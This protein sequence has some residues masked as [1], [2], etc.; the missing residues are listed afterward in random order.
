MIPVS[1][2]VCSSYSLELV[3]V[4]FL[5]FFEGAFTFIKRCHVIQDATLQEWGLSPQAALQTQ[6]KHTTAEKSQQT[7]PVQ[8]QTSLEKTLEKALRVLGSCNTWRC[9]GGWWS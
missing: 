3:C 1:A 6:R 9:E 8:F 5:I 4:L 7:T 2:T